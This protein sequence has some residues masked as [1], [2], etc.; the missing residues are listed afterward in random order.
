MSQPYGIMAA[1]AATVQQ[2]PTTLA[3]ILDK[4]VLAVEALGLIVSTTVLVGAAV[5]WF[6]RRNRFYLGTILA[7]IPICFA[8][9][10]YF[11]TITD[12]VSTNSHLVIR[13]IC[14]VLSAGQIS[15]LTTMRFGVFQSAGHAQWFTKRVYVAVLV[16]IYGVTLASTVVLCASYLQQ[17]GQPAFTSHPWRIPALAAELIITIA[18]DLVFTILSFVIVWRIR[19]EVLSA[20]T[21]AL[22]KSDTTLNNANNAHPRHA[23]VS[24]NIMNTPSG[25]KDVLASGGSQDTTSTP[26][27]TTP[28]AKKVGPTPPSRG[29]SA[30]D[31]AQTSGSGSAGGD[32]ARRGSK[33]PPPKR[34]RRR[35]FRLVAGL[36]LGVIVVMIL[37]SVVGMVLFI[38]GGGNMFGDTL[39]S[40][41]SRFYI[42]GALAQW[43]LVIEI[44]HAR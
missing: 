5:Q 40:L 19:A 16:L 14:M 15:A 31:L 10:W 35:R 23:I 25:S 41:F 24:T 39:A 2:N 6:R 32:A 1:A 44:M 37:S 42:L 43:A 27:A 33:K 18:A 30:N 29:A 7:A 28:A 12:Q 9:V 21:K 13:A 4:R 26:S 22:V 17:A 11:A 38:A 8:D 20:A 3:E 34:R 36:T